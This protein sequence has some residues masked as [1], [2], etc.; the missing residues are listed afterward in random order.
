MRSNNQHVHIYLRRH[1]SG[2][3]EALGMTL[4]NETSVSQFIDA[5][6]PIR[7]LTDATAIH[8][9]PEDDVYREH[10]ATS[11]DIMSSLSDLKVRRASCMRV[12][13]CERVES[14]Q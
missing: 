1:P 3:D 10:P 14:R 8:F 12:S 4:T 2:Y 5:S 6:D 13:A 11:E 9:R 7:L